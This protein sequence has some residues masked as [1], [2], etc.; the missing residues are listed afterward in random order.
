MINRLQQV[1]VAHL[2]I[3][4]GLL[5]DWLH[6]VPVV[7]KVRRVDGRD[8]QTKLRTL[9][10]AHREPGWIGEVILVWL[11]QLDGLR[12][13][14]RMTIA[15]PSN[16]IIEKTGLAIRCYEVELIAKVG[17]GYVHGKPQLEVDTAI[18]LHISLERFGVEDE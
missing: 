18:D 11:V 6:R 13:F 2:G 7:F 16:S 14:D 5:G 10:G 8:D 15:R 1:D 12:V 3:G 4:P 17:V 9:L